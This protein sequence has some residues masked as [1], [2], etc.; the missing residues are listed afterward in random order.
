MRLFTPTILWMLLGKGSADKPD[1]IFILADDLGEKVK[2]SGDNVKW[3]FS[4]GV[5]DVGWNNPSSPTSHL[6]SLAE[7]GVILDSAYTLPIC[8]P[9]RAAL[10]TGTVQ[11]SAGVDISYML[12]IVVMITNS[13]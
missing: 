1:I 6:D 10:L 4:P 3:S 13:S 8:S 5:N 7:E 2:F 11:F 9:S 12:F